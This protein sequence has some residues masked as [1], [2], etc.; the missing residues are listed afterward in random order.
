MRVFIPGHGERGSAR[1]SRG[2]NI[3]KIVD[4]GFLRP[5]RGHDDQF[6]VQR[7]LKAFVDA[8]WLSDFDERLARY[9]DHAAT[10]AP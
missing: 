1:R 6:E 10:D 8:Q 5:L 9:R 2:G 7:I 3:N 4:L